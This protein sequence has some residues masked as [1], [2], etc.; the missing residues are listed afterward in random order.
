MVVR[1]AGFLLLLAHLLLVAWLTLRPRDVAWVTAPN[2]TPLAGI[3]SDLVLGPAEAARRIADGLLLLA[4]LGV[5]LPMADG[6][7]TVSPW[8]SL[9]R[10]AAAG[11][12]VSLAVELLQTAVP[13][14]VVDVDSVL[15]N[16]TGVVLAHLLLVPAARAR[17]RRRSG[18]AR[19]SS[20]RR[21]RRAA[22]QGPTPT[23]PRVGIAP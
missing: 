4:P 5:L 23:I 12:L 20:S 13:G 8:A 18:T 7:L 15:L 6:R 21:S 11:A 2:L 16:T 17:L 14:Q 19:G 1:V 10:T 22:S 9:T 3:R